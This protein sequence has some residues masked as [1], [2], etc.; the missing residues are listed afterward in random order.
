LRRTQEE[1]DKIKA[2]IGSTVYMKLMIDSIKRE[3]TIPKQNSS[4]VDKIAF[5][6]KVREIAKEQIDDQDYSNAK[7]LYSR[8]CV[9]F[10]HM[11]RD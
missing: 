9:L 7:Q 2:A 10:R 5:S 8:A 4:F 1:K 11:S 3:P 6:E